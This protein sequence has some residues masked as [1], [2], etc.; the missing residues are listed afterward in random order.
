HRRRGRWRARRDRRAST[1]LCFVRLRYALLRD[2]Q[3][4]QPRF[5]QD[6]SDAFQSGRSVADQRDERTDVSCRPAR[7]GHAASVALQELRACLRHEKHAPTWNAKSAKFAKK[8]SICFAA[9]AAFAV[10]REL[11]C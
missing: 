10:F 4:V 7:S 3:T 5:L 6:R 8:D 2:V 1:S 9:F 11:K